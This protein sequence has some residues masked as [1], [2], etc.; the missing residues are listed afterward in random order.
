[1]LAA[2]GRCTRYWPPPRARNMEH[3]ILAPSS[4]PQWGNCSGSV[5]AQ[6]GLPDFDTEETREG[7]AAHWIGSEVLLNLQSPGRGPT[8]CDA[9]LE[10]TAPNGVRID[11][12]MAEG[13]QLY[14]DDVAEVCDRFEAWPYLTVEY[15][16]YM[17]QI[18]PQNW[19]TLDA[20]LYLP[21]RGLIFLWDYKHGHRECKPRENNQLIDYL[22]GIVHTFQIDG[23]TEQRTTAVTRIVQPFCYYATGPINEWVVQ[24]ADL[25]GHWNRLAQ[26]AEEALNNP[27][28]TT[29]LWCRDCLAVGKCSATRRARYNFIELV[30]Q[31]YEMDAM[32]GADLA[33]ESQILSDGIA[34][35]KA[36]K[37]AIDD[38][39]R[40]RISNGETGSGLVLESTTGRLDWTISPAQAIA[41]A[42][43]FGVD[44]TREAVKTPTQVKAA[45]PK[46]IR[47]LL[48][49]VMDGV[50]RRPAGSLKLVPAGES[51]SARAFKRK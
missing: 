29:G 15:R 49:Q 8:S 48:A 44:A 26:K 6:E 11:D 13:A 40:H 2:S 27:Q 41:L 21:D 37:E 51:R 42:A 19:G 18:H 39:L 46:E 35:A 1:M 33:V 25:R 5:R 17:P 50:T 7:N 10:K 43:Q 4:A 23:L 38:E 16:V 28:L 24:L 14:V 12:K 32:D 30:N 47:P 22:A 45:A 31:P 9:F 20:S 3:S 34:V 36:R